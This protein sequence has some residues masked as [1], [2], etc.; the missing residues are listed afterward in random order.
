MASQSDIQSKTVFKC[1]DVKKGTF[2]FSQIVSLEELANQHAK[3]KGHSTDDYGDSE[4]L[5]NCQHGLITTEPPHDKTYK[6]TARPAKTQIS[7]GIHPV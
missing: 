7:L 2:N 3:Q 4:I 5:T 1:A 6:M